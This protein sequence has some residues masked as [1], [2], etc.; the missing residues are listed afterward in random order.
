MT[1]RRGRSDRNGVGE[2]MEEVVVV[3]MARWRAEEVAGGD[4]G[5]ELKG[6]FQ[7]RSI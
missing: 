2:E 4:C 6:D 5:K 1:D 3:V 7:G